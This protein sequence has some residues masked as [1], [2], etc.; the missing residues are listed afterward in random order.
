MPARRRN[1]RRACRRCAYGCGSAVR[2][3]RDGCRWRCRAA[4]RPPARRGTAAPVRSRPCALRR[5]LPSVLR[6]GNVAAKAVAGHR[7]RSARLRPASR[8]VPPTPRQRPCSH[9]PS[10]RSSVSW[11]ASRANGTRRYS[12]ASCAVSRRR[13]S[14]GICV[15][16]TAIS[17]GI[18]GRPSR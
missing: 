2:R 13:I 14:V 8:R 17:G 3:V 16:V 6:G 11:P 4:P 1:A 18:E 15:G 7:R 10:R 9:V 5:R 12:A